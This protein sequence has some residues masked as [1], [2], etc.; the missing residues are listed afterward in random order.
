[1]VVCVP[2]CALR[3]WGVCWV[4]ARGNSR[5]WATSE[6]VRGC[7]RWWF[8]RLPGSVVG[9]VGVCRSL[10]LTRSPGSVA[11]WRGVVCDLVARFGGRLLLLPMVVMVLVVA[12]GVCVWWCVVVVTPAAGH[13]CRM[14]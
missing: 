1:M 7:V 2:V 8:T 14:R 11:W 4:G 9:S 5:S 10:P 12:A 3:G 13:S 6:G